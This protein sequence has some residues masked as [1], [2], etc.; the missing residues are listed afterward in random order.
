MTGVSVPKG[1]WIIVAD[2]GKAI[3][4]ENMGTPVAPQLEVKE[5]LRADD[6]PP[7]REQGADKPGRVFAGSHRSHVEQTD[8]HAM[9]GRQFLEIAAEALETA[10]TSHGVRSIV[11]VAPPKALAE[12]RNIVSASVKTSIVGELDKDLVHM[13]V[14]KIAEHL[15]A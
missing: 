2:H 13:P 9:A 12:L 6:N 7:T 3:L 11:L 1:A 5:V 4:L 15:A 8:W 14:A 10:R